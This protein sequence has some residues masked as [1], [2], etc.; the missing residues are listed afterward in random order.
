LVLGVITSTGDRSSAN[1]WWTQYLEFVAGRV[2]A[3]HAAGG[4]LGSEDVLHGDRE[5]PV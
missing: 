4:G 3:G 1:G 5:G 2:P